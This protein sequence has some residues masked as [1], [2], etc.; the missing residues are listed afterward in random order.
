MGTEITILIV[1]IGLALFGWLLFR[2]VAGLLPD[3]AVYLFALLLAL[4]LGVRGML[5]AYSPNIP[6]NWNTSFL[7][8]WFLTSASFWLIVTSAAGALL[9]L[10]F[11]RLR[12]KGEGA[13]R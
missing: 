12:S 3:R 7:V 5:N 4:G 9:L 6:E 2:I 13:S 1:P 11:R 8:G 10:G